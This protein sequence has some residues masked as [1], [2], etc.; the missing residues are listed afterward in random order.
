M[1]IHDLRAFPMDER[2]CSLV[3]HNDD[4]RAKWAGMTSV[5]ISKVGWGVWT[6]LGCERIEKTIVLSMKRSI[7]MW[8]WTLYAPT[9]LLFICSW[10]SFLIKTNPI[11]Y[12][13]IINTTAFFTTLIIVIANSRNVAQTSYP[14]AIDVWNV[15]IVTFAFLILLQSIFVG[16]KDVKGQKPPRRIYS[17]GDE[18]DEKMQWFNDTPYYAQLPERQPTALAKILDYIFRVI[19][20]TVFLVTCILYFIHY[21]YPYKS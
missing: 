7:L 16:K 17:F 18:C 14:K 9:V 4:F 10:L 5:T 20:P 8:I 3:F 11:E 15:Q 21:A 12:R 2:N 13:L 19:L 1:E 6:V